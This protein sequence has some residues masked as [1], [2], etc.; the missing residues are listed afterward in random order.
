LPRGGSTATRTERDDV[1][2]ETA[3]GRQ[4]RTAGRLE[5][6]WT[7]KDRRLLAHDDVTYE[8][9][10]PNDWRV[11]EVRLLD[12]VDTYGE[13]VEDNLLIQGDALHT[14]TALT[15][16]PEC[17]DRYLG[18]VKLVYIPRHLKCRSPR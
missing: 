16:V 1:G 17:A 4:S 8:W 2:G 14:L 3:T 12:V 5:L 18:K 10:D 13:D 7:N 15:S 11:S 6:T 9:V